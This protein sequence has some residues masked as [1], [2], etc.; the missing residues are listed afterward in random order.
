MA[1]GDMPGRLSLSKSDRE[2]LAKP[3]SRW[4]HAPTCDAGVIRAPDGGLRLASGLLSVVLND[5]ASPPHTLTQCVRW[6]ARLVAGGGSPADG[7]LKQTTS[8]FATSAA[9]TRQLAS[10]ASTRRCKASRSNFSETAF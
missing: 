10:R 2:Q 7:E 5:C 9:S 4:R 1:E 3:E 8:A 6:L